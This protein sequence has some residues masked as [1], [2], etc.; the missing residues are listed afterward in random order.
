MN[1]I[2]YRVN[3]LVD[4]GDHLEDVCCS[5]RRR[6][7]GENDLPVNKMF[8]MIENIGYRRP[9]VLTSSYKLK[10]YLFYCYVFVQFVYLLYGRM[11]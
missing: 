8:S 5:D 9:E 11:L 10:I 4:G 1:D 7:E 3:E 6:Y 2:G